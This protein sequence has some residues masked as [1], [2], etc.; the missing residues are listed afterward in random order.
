[1]IGWLVIF[2][3]K[4]ILIESNE[5]W[6]LN[7]FMFLPALQAHFFKKSPFGDLQLQNGRKKKNFGRQTKKYIITVISRGGHFVYV[8]WSS[9]TPS[10]TFATLSF[11]KL[12]RFLACWLKHC[13]NGPDKEKEEISM[14]GSRNDLLQRCWDRVTNRQWHA[15]SFKSIKL[16]ILICREDQVNN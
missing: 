12:F 14:S 11:A 13:S 8:T 3:T 10:A 1:M 15:K 9:T 5:G 6:F 4:K 16:A 2:K 7:N